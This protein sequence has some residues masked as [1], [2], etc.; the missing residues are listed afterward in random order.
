MIDFKEEIAK[1]ISNAINIDYR[2]LINYIEIPPETEMGDYAFPCFRLAKELKKSPVMIAEEINNQIQIDTNIIENIKVTGGYIN[3]Y[4]N[5]LTLT[6]NVL[7]HIDIEKE[8]YGLQN[9]FI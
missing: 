9:H 5:K 2:E 7:S 1:T 4:I 6:S 8:N 3:F